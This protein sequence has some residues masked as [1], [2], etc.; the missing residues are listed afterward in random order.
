MIFSFHLYLLGSRTN[1]ADLHFFSC[2]EVVLEAVS[3]CGYAA[4]L[5]QP[6]SGRVSEVEDDI[7]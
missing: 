7:G 4:T 2:E 3:R 1:S 5:V 6:P